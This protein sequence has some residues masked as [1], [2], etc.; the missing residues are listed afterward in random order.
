MSKKLETIAIA[1]ATDQQLRAYALMFLQL[2]INKQASTETIIAKIK[3]A[4]THE[5]ITIVI[6][7]DGEQDGAPP[8]SHDEQGKPYITQPLTPAADGRLFDNDSSKDPRITINIFEGTGKFGKRPI[9][10]GVNGR[11]MLLPRN[12]DINIPYR[13]Y[14]A[15]K[16]AVQTEVHDEANERDATQIDRTSSDV[17]SYPFSVVL[18]PSKKELEDWAESKRAAQRKQVEAE[19]R[20][21]QRAA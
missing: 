13:Y 15:L 17:P 16:D 14:L 4:Q 2:D 18:P 8:P 10:V 3:E 6:E 20:K 9:P 5:N 19:Q 1:E 21:A 12:K 7:D 11:T